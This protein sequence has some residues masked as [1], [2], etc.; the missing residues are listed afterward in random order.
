VLGSVE[1]RK[2]LVELVEHYHR[3]RDRVDCQLVIAGPI[4]WKS[5][6]LY[7]KVSDSDFGDDV[8]FVGYLRDEQV[9]WCYKNCAVFCF[10]SIYEGF[11]IPPFEA[12]QVGARVIGTIYS[13]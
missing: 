5:H 3:V 4:G 7:R 11:G 2:N 10:P 9:N 6:D 8:L 1:P 13:E 12:L